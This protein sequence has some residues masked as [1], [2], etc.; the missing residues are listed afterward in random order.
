MYS[1]IAFS[2]RP[3]R[4]DEVPTRPEALPHEIALSFA[5]DRRKMDSALALDVPDHFNTAY[6]GGIDKSM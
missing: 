1:R 5:I 2:S 3:N 4:A 6:F